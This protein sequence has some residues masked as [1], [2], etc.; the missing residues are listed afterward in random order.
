MIDEH[1]TIIAIAPV[2]SVYDK[3]ASNIEEIKSRRGKIIVI[4]TE[5]NEK[6]KHIAEV[7]LCIRKIL[8]IFTLTLFEV[9]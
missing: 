7:W 5:G 4:T 2:D 3:I 6:I 1:F 9:F 8:E